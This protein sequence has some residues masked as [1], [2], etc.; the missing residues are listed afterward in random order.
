MAGNP[1]L[2]VLAAL[3]ALQ[4]SAA[5]ETPDYR[6]GISLLHD[7]KYPAD[8]T[9]FEFAN[10]D[11]PKGGRIVL[12]S[13]MQIVNLSGQQ[14]P[15][16]PNAPGYGR[17][18]DRLFMRTGDELSG[19]YGWLVRGV[20]LSSDRKTLRLK[21]HDTARWHDGAPITSTDVKFSFDALMRRPFGKRYFESWIARLEVTGPHDLTIHHRRVFTNANLAALVWFRI[22]PAHYWEGRDSEQATLVPPVGSGPYRIR[23]FDRSRIVYERVEDYWGRDLPIHRGRYN[24]DEIR[25][26]VYRDATVAREGFRKGLFDIH[27]ETDM[28]HWRN[29]YDTPARDKGWMRAD[30]RHI[31]KF[32]GMQTAIAFNLDRDRFADVRVREALTVALDFEWQNRVFRFGSQERALSYFARSP[33]AAAGIPSGEELRLLSQFRDQL[34]ARVFQEPFALPVSAGRGHHRPALERARAL[35]ADAGWTVAGGR[36]VDARGQQ[37]RLDLLTNNPAHRRVL[38]PYIEVLKLLGIDV[39]LR[40]VDSLIAVN[41][42]RRRDFDAY[43]R[44]HDFLNPPVGELRSYF[45]SETAELELSSNI[46]GIRDPIVDALIE[47]AEQAENIEA[48]AVALRALD[49]VLLWGF[50]HVPLHVIEEERF[51]WWDKFE[52]P[53]R[54]A[55]AR[56][57]YLVGSSLRILDSWWFDPERAAR[58]EHAGN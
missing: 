18:Q 32:I 39:R 41:F 52:R 7:L 11:A 36:L 33:F 47:E 37:F 22:R 2:G 43:V 19:I 5:A 16:L 55:A 45:G 35:L 6:H 1:G 3:L 29:S 14:G 9:H 48:A 30:I 44:G 23:E 40:L 26:E 4:W 28:G 49:R 8:F 34:P 53:E 20:A 46:P 10:P 31:S 38:L 56:Y 15:E 50:Y 24:F 58:L 27:F 51:L 13:T 25:Y 17:T 42:R 21:L 54:E 57:E 12:S